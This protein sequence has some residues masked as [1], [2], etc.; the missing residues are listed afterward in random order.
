MLSGLPM[1]YDQAILIQWLKERDARPTLR[2]IPKIA[3]I[4]D[5]LEQKAYHLISSI[6]SNTRTN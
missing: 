5:S 2:P 1:F 3:S 6:R 4:N